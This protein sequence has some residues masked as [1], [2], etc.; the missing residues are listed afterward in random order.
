MKADIGI[1]G[2]GVMGSHLARSFAHHGYTVA[3]HNRSA[4]RTDAL[5]AEHGDEGIFLPAAFINEFVGSL[6]RHG[7]PW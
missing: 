4:G 5:V 2:L 1:T 3:V 7:G 6:E